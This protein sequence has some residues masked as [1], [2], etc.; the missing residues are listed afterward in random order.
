MYLT[1]DL[2]TEYNGVVYRILDTLPSDYYLVVEEQD[3]QKGKF[4]MPTY[5]IPAVFKPV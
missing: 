4:P 3:F 5:I 1:T 2:K